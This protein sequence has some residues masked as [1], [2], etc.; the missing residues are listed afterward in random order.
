VSAARISFSNDFL[1][2]LT[3]PNVVEAIAM[4]FMS[5]AEYGRHRGVSREAVRKAVAEGR[6]SMVTGPKGKPGVDKD[7]ADKAW[8]A[9]T[10]AQAEAY[11]AKVAEPTEEVSYNDARTE[12]EQIQ[13]K[14]LKLKYDELSGE[15]VSAKDVET[16]WANLATKVKTKVLGI[17]SKMKQRYSDLTLEQYGYLDQ[18]A[19]E[20]LEELADG[21]D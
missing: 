4:Q 16:E 20:A 10:K 17:A 14:L 12:K 3:V 13:T 9:N 6:I 8:A 15:L 21:K 5:Y 1:K 11:V 18:I 7:A 19:R 2:Q